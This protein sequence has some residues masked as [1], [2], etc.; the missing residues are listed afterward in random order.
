MDTHKAK[1][2]ILARFNATFGIL[3]GENM[4]EILL[5]QGK[6]ALVDDEDFEELNKFNWHAHKDKNKF[7]AEH[8]EWDKKNKNVKHIKMHRFLMAISQK[9]KIDRKDGN[10]L[11]N[12]ENLLEP[13]L[14]NKNEFVF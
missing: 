1:C 13:I 3:F 10:G 5:T 14:G 2:V 9:V 6:V 12:L 4:K 11:N 7:Y 8:S